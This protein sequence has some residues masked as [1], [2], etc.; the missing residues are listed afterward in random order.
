MDA[1]LFLSA[2][3]CSC[4]VISGSAR[5]QG[6]QQTIGDVTRQQHEAWVFASLQR[7]E[8]IKPGM[9]R[10]DFLKVFRLEGGLYRSNFSGHYAFRDCLYFK[11]DV[12]FEAVGRSISAADI[13]KTISK[14]YIERGIVD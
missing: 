1:R 13:I 10:G 5:A 12:E 3:L 7:M 6:Q 14:P 9:T 2:V 4:V 8:A 11:V